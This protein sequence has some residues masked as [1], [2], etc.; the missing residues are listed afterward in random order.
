MSVN[1]SREAAYSEKTPYEL[2]QESEGVP[3]VRGHCVEDL[4]AV[5]VATW[6]RKGVPGC[7][8]NLIGAGRTC[9]VQVSEIPARQNTK[10]QRFM[11]EQLVY[12]VKGRGATTVWNEEGKR[13]TFEW[14]E[15]SL[16]SPPLNAW[17]QPFNEQGDSAERLIAL[18]D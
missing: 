18:T 10:P 16:F 3:I 5:Q 7:F 2:W 14:Q 12:I 15:G 8:I 9:D 13:Q 11:F 1:L 17:H 4:S 6:E